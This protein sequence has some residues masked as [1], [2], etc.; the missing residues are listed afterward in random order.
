MKIRSKVRQARLDYQAQIGRPV[1]LK[2]VA[3]A[4]GITES[5]LSRIERGLTQRVDFET[6]AKL[7]K[8]YGMT[9]GDLLEYVE[10]NSPVLAAA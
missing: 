2:E 5:A 1:D 7:C 4:T 10:A 8:F 6:L 3:E 9:P